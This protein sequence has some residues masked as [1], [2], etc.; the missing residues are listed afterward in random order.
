MHCPN[1]DTEHLQHT[2]CSSCYPPLWGM[3]K[4]AFTMST[5]K[6]CTTLELW[7]KFYL[8]QNEDCSPGGSISDSSERLLQIGS[9]GKIIYKVL[10]KG[11]FSTMKHSFY[12]KAFC[13]SWGSDITMKGFSASLD[14]RRCK[15]WDHKNLFLKISNHLKTCPTRFPGA[16]SASLHPDSLRGCWRST[17]IAAWGSI[18][19]EADG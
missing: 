9:G 18:S 11:E 3:L 7:V 10:V 8:G 4:L 6:R 17:A 2:R 16:Q 5:K 12:K 15:D 13:W 1:E 14:M 19:T